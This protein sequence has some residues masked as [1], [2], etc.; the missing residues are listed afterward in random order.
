VKGKITKLNAW[1]TGK[2]SLIGIDGNEYIILAGTSC[3]VGDVVE[4]E[5]GNKFVYGKQV[6][7][8]LLPPLEAFMDNHPEMAINP[9][10]PRSAP[11]LRAHD[12]PQ[13]S[14][15]KDSREAYWQAKE[16]RDIEREPI[17]TRLSCISSAAQVYS[18]AQGQ[19]EKILELAR[20][21]EAYANGKQ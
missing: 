3:K 8:K 9:D 11:L 7:S 19:D 16:K 14:A 12:T 1:K 18:G 20:K 2:G 6:L 4:Y 17:I 10:N 21:F 15:N 13:A 5:I